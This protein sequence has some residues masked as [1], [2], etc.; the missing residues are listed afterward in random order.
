MMRLSLTTEV[1]RPSLLKLETLLIICQEGGT[2]IGRL[3]SLGR[4]EIIFSTDD[5][6]SIETD[7]SAGFRW[8]G[9]FINISELVKYRED[10]RDGERTVR[11][12]IRTIEGDDRSML[13][14]LLAGRVR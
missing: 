9:K 3:R 7:F 13:E 11:A 10:R 12:R 14:E 1:E 4:N 8:D 5:N 6:Q 2:T